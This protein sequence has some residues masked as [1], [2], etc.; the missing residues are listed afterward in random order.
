MLRIDWQ[1]KERCQLKLTEA[2]WQIGLLV[3]E[4]L[5]GDHSPEGV[6][7]L[8]EIAVRKLLRQ[9]VDEQVGAVRALVLL[10][11]GHAAVVGDGSSSDGVGAGAAAAAGGNSLLLLLLLGQ[12]GRGGQNGWN[13]CKLI[14]AILLLSVC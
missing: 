12:R 5:G 6:E 2:L 8:E 7:G 3:D 13:A 14:E 4:N 1:I 11:T 9:V 10:K